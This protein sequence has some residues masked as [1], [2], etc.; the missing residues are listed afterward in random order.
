M[1]KQ[2][3]KE[4]DPLYNE[5]A[6]IVLDTG[7]QSVSGIVHQIEQLLAQKIKIN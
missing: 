3:F 1:I 6:T 4:R 2:L 7:G 5:I